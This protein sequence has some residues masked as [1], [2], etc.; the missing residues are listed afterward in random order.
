MA[1]YEFS[2]QRRL[3][4]AAEYRQ[5]FENALCK[6]SDQHLLILAIPNEYDQSRLGVIIAKKNVR[7]AV[8]RNKVKRLVRE[9][10]RH[11]AQFPVSVDLVMLARNG[12]DDL[13]GTDLHRLLEYQ[14][15]RLR[16]KLLKM[17][18]QL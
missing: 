15:Q 12:I 16:K 11:Q 13:V 9:S 8:S 17:S 18:L 2:Q 10:F 1:Q 6:I 5:V 4:N 14:W 7:L 3:L